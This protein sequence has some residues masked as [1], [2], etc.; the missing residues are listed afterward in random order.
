M[1]HISR[2]QPAAAVPLL[3]AS[4]ALAACGSSSKSPSTSS[5]AAAGA[6]TGAIPSTSAGASRISALRGCLQKNGV[7]LPKPG[8]GGAL[9]GLLLYGRGRPL[10]KGLSR[11]QYEAALKKCAG[12]LP[13][14]RPFNS[15]TGR[16][17]L[18]R[19]AA[20]MR[21]NGTNLPAPKTGKGPLFN[22]KGLN[23]SS[24]QFRAAFVKCRANLS[25]ILGSARP[26]AGAAGTSTAPA[27]GASG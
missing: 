23:T 8:A 4:L 25:S 2:R 18:V 27:P 15:A 24:P 9:G 12:S 20:C 16:Q 6:R 10:P 19:F 26:G 14:R 5:A 11:A 7:T 13:P 17:A 22:T 21:Q 3:C 1:S